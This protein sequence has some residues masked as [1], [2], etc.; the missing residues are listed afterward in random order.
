MWTFTKARIH[1]A[2][3]QW[4]VFT[5]T[6]VGATMTVKS[7]TLNWGKFYK[8]GNKDDEVPISDIEGHQIAPGVSYVIS[9]CGRSD[10]SSGTEGSFDLYDGATKVGN[11]YWDCP[12]GSK[13]NTS[14]WTPADA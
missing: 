4:A 1:M 9:T 5:I 2:Y 11:Y 7:V 13:T 3:A 8:N 12:W 10:A 14:K 6:T